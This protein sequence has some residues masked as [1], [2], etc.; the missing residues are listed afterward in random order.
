[1]P[2]EYVIRISGTD[3]SD[4]DFAARITS[5]LREGWVPVGGVTVYTLGEPGRGQSARLAQAMMRD[6][7]SAAAARGL[8]RGKQHVAAF[9]E[10]EKREGKRHGGR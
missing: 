10:I 5:M 8:E 3:E 9:K 6:P 7:E 4:D 2:K 1:M